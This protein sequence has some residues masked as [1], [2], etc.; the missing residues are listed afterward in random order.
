MQFHR[1]FVF[2]FCYSVFISN[3]SVKSGFSTSS[4]ARV[5]RIEPV[6]LFASNKPA[7]NPS[8]HTRSE[9]ISSVSTFSSTA[10]ETQP[11]PIQNEPIQSSS[12]SFNGV[13]PRTI[14]ESEPRP[15]S[16]SELQRTFESERQPM[17]DR[18]K[19][20]RFMETVDLHDAS[21]G[22][23]SDGHINPAQHGVYARVRSAVLRFGGAVAVGTA[24]GAGIVTITHHAN[25]KMK[26]TD[27]IT[28]TTVNPEELNIQM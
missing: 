14:P 25:N 24:V 18:A 5:G 17:I 2:A 20:V 23:H 21:V 16:E 19:H 8:V 26:T 13:E 1:F 22:T 11:K 27:E 4:I 9:S 7:N 10:S 3:N 28:T 6:R 12:S 15:I